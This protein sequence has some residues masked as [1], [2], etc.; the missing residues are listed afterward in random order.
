MFDSVV[1]DRRSLNVLLKCFNRDSSSDDAFSYAMKLNLCLF[2]EDSTSESKA[3][4]LDFLTCFAV[5]D[6]VIDNFLRFLLVKFFWNL[7][8]Q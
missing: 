3:V 1:D 7:V 4:D 2:D 5:S 6:D 8:V